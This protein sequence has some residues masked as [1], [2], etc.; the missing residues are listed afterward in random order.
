MANGADGSKNGFS[1]FGLTF[2]VC[3]RTI[4]CEARRKSACLFRIKEGRGIRDFFDAR[5]ALEFSPRSAA[6]EIMNETRRQRFALKGAIEVSANF[7]VGSGKIPNSKF[8][9]FAGGSRGWGR[10]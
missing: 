7:F 5:T 9:H 2:F 1:F 6:R 3:E 4:P 8:G 10:T